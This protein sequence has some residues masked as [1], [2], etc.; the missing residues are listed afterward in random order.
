MIESYGSWAEML[1]LKTLSVLCQD[2]LKT[3]FL[4]SWSW[5]WRNWKWSFRP[6]VP[7]WEMPC[8]K[9][10][11]TC[12]VLATEWL[13]WVLFNVLFGVLYWSW[14]WRSGVLVLVLDV[15][16]TSLVMNHEMTHCPLWDNS[17]QSMPVFYELGKYSIGTHID[18]YCMFVF[19]EFQKVL[20]TTC[21]RPPPAQLNYSTHFPPAS[22]TSTWTCC[23]PATFKWTSLEI[24]FSNFLKNFCSPQHRRSFW[25][26]I[27]QSPKCSTRPRLQ[28]LRLEM[29]RF[30]HRVR[31]SETPTVRWFRWVFSKPRWTTSIQRRSLRP[32]T[33]K[34]MSLDLSSAMTALR[35]PQ[36]FSTCRQNGW[37]RRV[38]TPPI[39]RFHSDATTAPVL[40]CR[41]AAISRRNDAHCQ[42]TL[43]Q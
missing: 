40:Y 22:K 43:S 28:S 2:S 32:S 12:I 25:S 26:F 23:R 21:C 9:C 38:L 41:R 42:Q 39:R 11:C 29:E 8:L 20:L 34:M 3:G 5:T 15:L 30:R 18:L 27:L 19:T 33:S 35:Q 1:S 17:P 14:F 6:F 24:T 4:V 7:E 16:L 37:P 13:N 10:R 36:P 31:N